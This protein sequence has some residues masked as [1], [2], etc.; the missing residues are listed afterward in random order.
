MGIV[1]VNENQTIAPFVSLDEAVLRIHRKWERVVDAE[2]RTHTA[3]IE[4]GMDLV[5]LRAR[6][7]AGEA[8]GISWWNWYALKFTRDRRDTERVM[9]IASAANPAAAHEAEKAA[10]RQRM[11]AFRARTGAQSQC[12]PEQERKSAPGAARSGGHVG[13]AWCG[14][15]HCRE[16]MTQNC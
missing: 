1:T 10:T 3:R 6:I 12:A 16:F 4:C 2:H 5:A 9:A 13:R 15:P 7:E 11:Q 14:Q 8:G